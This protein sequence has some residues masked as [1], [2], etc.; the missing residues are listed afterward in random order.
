MNCKICSKL[1]QE[2]QAP[3]RKI[4]GIAVLLWFISLSMPGVVFFQNNEFFS[5]SPLGKEA[6]DTFLGIHI[7]LIGWIGIIV[8]YVGWFA[9][10]LFAFSIANT[11]LNN[12]AAKF[13][14]IGAV[15]LS[16]DSFRFE[17]FPTG[18]PTYE[19]YGIGIGGF[20]WMV[21]ISLSLLAAVINEIEIALKGQQSHS[22]TPSS[23]GIFSVFLAARHT[24][25]AFLLWVSL[26]CIGVLVCLFLILGIVD[27]MQ[28]NDDELKKLN[29]SQVVFKRSEICSQTPKVENQIL[30]NGP[31]ELINPNPYKLISPEALLVMGVP[32]VRERAE[33]KILRNPNQPFNDYHSGIYYEHY[34]EDSNNLRT[35]KLREATGEAAARLE[36]L[37]LPNIEG[38]NDASD[39]MVPRYR[40]TLVSNNG[41]IGFDQIWMKQ[42]TYKFCPNLHEQTSKNFSLEKLIKQTLVFQ[43]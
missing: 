1:V 25:K 8:T 14:A 19:V 21:A 24:G 2:F 23:Q 7:L 42:Y 28:G 6:S 15:A 40:I 43:K 10:G 35:M 29:Q 37:E 34:L 32:A 5:G 16:L 31:L 27:R 36:I 30:L 22:D 3:S 13:F 4:A 33:Y 11:W 39:R 20:I 18:G 41:V 38:A 9:N 12:T 26:L 17:F